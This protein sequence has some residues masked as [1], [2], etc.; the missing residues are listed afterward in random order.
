[1]KLGL[2]Q[3][4]ILIDSASSLK[5]KRRVVKSIKDRLHREHMVSVAEIGDLEIWNRASL[6]L[7]AVS[8]DGAYLRGVLDAVIRKLKDLPEGRLGDVA[9][10]VVDVADVVSFEDEDGTALWTEAERR[11]AGEAA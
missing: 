1:M 2:L 3:F 8:A 5:D 10:D 11:E 7:A 4:S 9:A 6:G